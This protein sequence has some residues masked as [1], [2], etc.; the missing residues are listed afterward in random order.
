VG[1]YKSKNLAKKIYQSFK[2][3]SF[4]AQIFVGS[5]IIVGVDFLIT[6]LSGKRDLRR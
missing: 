1:N 2:K 3:I 5:S 4:S 6:G